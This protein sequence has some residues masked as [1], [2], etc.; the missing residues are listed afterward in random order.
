MN[1][2]IPQLNPMALTVADA[3]HLL[4]RVGGQAVSEAAIRADV[5]AGAPANADGT[6]NLVL[7]AAWLVS[8]M[9][10]GN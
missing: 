6:L 9:A 5:A 10:D 4:T 1:E 3:A 2:P 8:E 7:Y